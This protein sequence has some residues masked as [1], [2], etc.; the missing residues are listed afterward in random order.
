MLRRPVVIALS[1]VVLFGLVACGD[2]SGSETE[3]SA[4]PLADTDGLAGTSWVLTEYTD[5]SGDTVPAV[6]EPASLSFT[7]D[8]VAGSTPCN[9]FNGSYTLDGDALTIDMGAMTQRACS[10]D[11]QAQEDALLQLFPEVASFVIDDGDALILTDDADTSL[12]VYEADPSTLVGDWTATGV[13]NGSDAV[14]S[15]AQ[16]EAL[17]A[18]FAEDGTLSGSGGCN[19]FNAGYTVEGADGLIIGPIAST[20]MACSDDVMAAE[21]AYFAALENVATYSVSAGTLTLRDADGA[22]QVTYIAG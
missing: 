14:E 1:L 8:A 12:L 21:S 22:T 5:A 16:T 2:D 19:T 7:T 13:N 18:T 6:A 3:G 11:V 10:G 4:V 20:R 17:T 9:Q 15:N